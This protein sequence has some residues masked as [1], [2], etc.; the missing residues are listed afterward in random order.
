MWSWLGVWLWVLQLDFE[1]I[2]IW[3]LDAVGLIAVTLKCFM[4]SLH[5]DLRGA[6]ECPYQ[7]RVV[8]I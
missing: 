7:F 2:M 1:D 6:A 5:G 8:K 4:L 3:Y